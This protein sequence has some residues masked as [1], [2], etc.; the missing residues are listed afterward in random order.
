MP[1][2][3]NRLKARKRVGNDDPGN[4]LNK[5]HRKVVDDL[6]RRDGSAAPAE[7][8]EKVIQADQRLRKAVAD[9]FVC[10]EESGNH[11]MAV[12]ILS[13]HTAILVEM[14]NRFKNG[15]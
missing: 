12:D 4:I 13:E 10:L 2:R 14:I 5:V 8:M 11:A 9:L 15:R 1:E 6:L 3:R 7:K